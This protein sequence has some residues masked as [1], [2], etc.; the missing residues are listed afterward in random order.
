MLHLLFA[1]LE[2]TD[3]TPPGTASSSDP[4][5]FLAWEVCQVQRET[6]LSEN[7][8][9]KNQTTNTTNNSVNKRENH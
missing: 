5:A 4:T 9:K 1:K 8:V 6:V 3:K 7:T 2:T